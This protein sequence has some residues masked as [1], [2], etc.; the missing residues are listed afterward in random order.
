[1][2]GTSLFPNWLQSLLLLLF[3]GI[4]V[5]LALQQASEL[6]K[7]QKSS[8]KQVYTVILCGDKEK[9]RFFKEGDYV[10]GRDNC[11][12]EEGIITKIYAVIPEESKK[13]PMT[14]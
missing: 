9:T 12:D 5:I 1:M 13:K 14:T 10:G 11:N 7:L 6:K 3:I 4:A 2:T 8:K